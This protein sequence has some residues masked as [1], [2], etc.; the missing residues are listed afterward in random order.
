MK[1][2]PSFS[3]SP[4]VGAMDKLAR[5]TFMRIPEAVQGQ[6][7]WDDVAWDTLEA[8][9]YVLGLPTAQVRITGEY[10]TDVLTNQAHPETPQQALHDLLFRREQPR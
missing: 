5:I 7:P 9:G 10:I 2:A 3:L 4:V 1:F 6:R 8:S